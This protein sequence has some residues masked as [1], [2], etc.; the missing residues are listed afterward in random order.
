MASLTPH[1]SP[2]IG[3]HGPEIT[4]LLLDVVETSTR[5]T[6]PRN[7]IKLIIVQDAILTILYIYIY[8]YIYICQV[9]QTFL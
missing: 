5:P 3:F 7:V 4:S 1:P 8:I 6:E 9:L 2:Q